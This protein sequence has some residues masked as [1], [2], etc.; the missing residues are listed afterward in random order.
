MLETRDII[1]ITLESNILVNILQRVSSVIIQKSVREGFGLTV[2]EA[3]WK[4]TPVVAS[5]KGGIPLQIQN[6]KSGYLLEPTDNEGFAERVM[7][8]LDHPDIA[9]EFGRRGREYVRKNFLITRLLQDYLN[10]IEE[11]L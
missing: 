5:N 6:G 2:T 8:L 7:Y 10:L 11:L 3:L 1:L 9:K 4:G